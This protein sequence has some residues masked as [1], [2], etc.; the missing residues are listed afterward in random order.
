MY[1]HRKVTVVFTAKVYDAPFFEDEDGNPVT[2]LVPIELDLKE[3]E[4][5]P[6][7]PK[8]ITYSSPIAKDNE[9]LPI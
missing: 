2:S 4:Q 1:A 5:T 7:V 9:E 6:D 3:I 8:L